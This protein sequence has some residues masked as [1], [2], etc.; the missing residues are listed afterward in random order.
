M[1]AWRSLPVSCKCKI[2]VGSGVHGAHYHAET[3]RSRGCKGSGECKGK[4]GSVM[5][6]AQ[7]GSSERTRVC[8]C[9][10]SGECKGKVGSDEWSTR[11][12]LGEYK[13]MRVQG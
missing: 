6:R 2:R 12:K 13:G 10:G 11:R 4:V 3:A 8:G 1:A 5:S 9:K 7:E